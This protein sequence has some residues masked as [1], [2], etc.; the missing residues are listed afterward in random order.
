[1]RELRLAQINKSEYNYLF[2]KL[3]QPGTNQPF[4]FNSASLVT[5]TIPK[6]QTTN[7]NNQF[8]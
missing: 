8:Q 7:V 2:E 3:P 5:H 1:V 6:H 4:S